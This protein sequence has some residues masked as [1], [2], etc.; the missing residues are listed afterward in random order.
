[1]DLTLDLILKYPLIRSYQTDQDTLFEGIILLCNKDFNISIRKRPDC[2]YKLNYLD[3]K[4]SKILQDIHDYLKCNKNS[5]IIEVLDKIKTFL[6]LNEPNANIIDVSDAHLRVLH[7]Y[8]EFTNFFLNLETCSL[9]KDLTEINV[10]IL[11]EKSRTHC[12]KILV[13]YSTDLAHTFYFKSIDLPGK[14][15]DILRSSDS[16]TALFDGFLG[17]IDLL[18][19]F[20]DIMDELDEHCTILDPERPVRKDYYRRIWLGENVSATIT[21]DPYNVHLR[22]DVRFLGPSRLVKN[23]GIKLNENFSKWDCQQ[24]FLYAVQLL[25]GLESFPKRLEKKKSVGILVEYGECSI[26]FSLR[27]DNKPPDIICPNKSCEKFYHNRCIYEW[28]VSLDSKKVFNNISGS[29]PSCEK[30]ISCPVLE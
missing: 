29:C 26:C 19:P 30:I 7:E 11:D 9:S 13:N 3:T 28:L 27:L 6:T 12:T 25:L 22:P 24:G 20:F 15:P 5:T 2:S 18:Q 10:S 17:K 4:N 8:S 21:V 23:Y 16:L 1:M 14:D